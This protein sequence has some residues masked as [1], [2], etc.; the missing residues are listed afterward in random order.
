MKSG[1]LKGRGKVV[2]GTV[3]L[4][5][6]VFHNEVKTVVIRELQDLYDSVFDNN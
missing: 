6:D 4:L 1:R 3:M 2:E 5:I